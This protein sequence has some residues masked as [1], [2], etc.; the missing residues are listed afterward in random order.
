M[1][2]KTLSVLCF[3]SIFA[4][5][6][7]S[8][9]NANKKQ[10]EDKA[11]TETAVNHPIEVDELLRNA[12]R[13]VEKEISVS[14]ICTHICSH[15]GGK[16]FLMG[17]DD[18]KVIKVEAGEKIGSFKPETVN[19]MVEVKGILKE[20]RID[21]AFLADWEAKIK[22]G[23][24]EKHGQGEGGCD[25]E[26]KARNEASAYSAQ[27][28]IENFRKKIAERNEKEGKNYLSFYHIEA[29]SYIIK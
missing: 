6:M 5:S 23:T 9:K 28:R 27:E 7:Y 16:I 26:K 8:C 29:I 19:S 11:K 25:T 22:Q 3:L 18:S 17:S 4:L 10:K 20:E 12:A 2:K 21:E 14:G 15:G 24:E 1:K 13:L